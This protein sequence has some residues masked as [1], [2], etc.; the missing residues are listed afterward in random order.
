[1]IVG[2]TDL[3][4]SRFV[5]SNETEAYV[6]V[7]RRQQQSSKNPFAELTVGS[8]AVYRLI[9]FDIGLLEIRGFVFKMVNR[10]DVNW[11]Y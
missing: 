5:I 2:Y 4:W 10:G 9:K 8:K 11:K 7:V 6:L 1:M 3:K